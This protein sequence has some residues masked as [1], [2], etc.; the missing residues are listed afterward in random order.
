MVGTKSETLT[1][2]SSSEI[3]FKPT[4]INGSDYNNDEVTEKL[5]YVQW[6]FW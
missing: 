6:W 3:F 2:K 5:D 4:F 1:G